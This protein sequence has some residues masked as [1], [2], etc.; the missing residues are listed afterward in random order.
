M[1]QP[2]AHLEHAHAGFQVPRI[3]MGD[4]QNK[5]PFQHLTS[6][7]KSNP[8]H[9]TWKKFHC[10]WHQEVDTEYQMDCF[11]DTCWG[12]F[13]VLP[14]GRGN[15]PYQPVSPHHGQWA[16]EEGYSRDQ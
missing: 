1:V 12:R 13:S 16:T 10:G 5:L 14:A 15:K 11:L 9:W 7:G 8:K 3:S 6:S 4:R 2:C